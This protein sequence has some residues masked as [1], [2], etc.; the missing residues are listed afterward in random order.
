MN[1]KSLNEFVGL[2]L[3]LLLFAVSRELRVS[4]D[5]LRAAI[6]KTFDDDI[7]KSRLKRILAA[8]Y[9]DRDS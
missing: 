9:S 8:S 7:L 3:L 2:R 6:E 1:F 4:E 5:Y